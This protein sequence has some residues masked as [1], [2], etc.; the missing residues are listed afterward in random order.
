MEQNVN[1]LLVV[2]EIQL[3]YKPEIVTPPYLGQLVNIQMQS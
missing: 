2:S 1:N 3:V